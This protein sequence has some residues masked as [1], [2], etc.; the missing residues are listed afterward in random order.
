MGM[1]PYDARLS[2]FLFNKTRRGLLALLYGHT[3]EAFYV[4]QIVRALGSGSGAVQRELKLMTE[5]GIAL[6]TRKGNLV[7]YQA[8]PGSRVFGELKSITAW[9]V[10]NQPVPESPARA[11]SPASHRFTVSRRRLAE[12]CRKHHIKRLSLFGSVLREDFRPDS[13]VDVL[14]EFERSHVPGFGIVAMEN[15]LSRMAGRKVDLRTP[16][17]LSR[18]FRE[19]VVREAQVHYAAA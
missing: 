13:D 17:D 19:Q 4:N 8:N 12:F 7:Y 3:D 10:R 16:N 15:E 9:M 6:R 5:A 2:S 14:V 1:H 18:Y 11:A